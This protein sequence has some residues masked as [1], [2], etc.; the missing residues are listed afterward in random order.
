MLFNPRGNEGG[1][2]YLLQEA[3]IQCLCSTKSCKGSRVIYVLRPME[4]LFLE[5]VLFDVLEPRH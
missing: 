1:D 5:D 2:H 3:I 4:Q